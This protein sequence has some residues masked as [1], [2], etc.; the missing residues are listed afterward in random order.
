GQVEERRDDERVPAPS[1]EEHVPPHSGQREEDER[2]S[3]RREELAAQEKRRAH[4]NEPRDR[5]QRARP[6]DRR[7]EEEQREAIRLQVKNADQ[8]VRLLLSVRDR[9]DRVG[10]VFPAPGQIEARRDQDDLIL[11]ERVRNAVEPEEP[12]RRSQENRRGGENPQLPA[13]ERN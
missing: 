2:R 7:P 4:R 12:R 10:E 11:E 1:R 3:A 6:R 13:G 8:P 9:T 5:R